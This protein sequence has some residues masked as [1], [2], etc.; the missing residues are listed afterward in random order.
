MKIIN[1]ERRSN[2][3]FILDEID[4][5]KDNPIIE[6]FA[7]ILSEHLAHLVKIFISFDSK[8]PLI[9]SHA[10]C[11]N[12]LIDN[13]IEISIKYLIQQWSVIY[14]NEIISTSNLMRF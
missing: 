12:D 13:F 4:E 6:N 10:N 8:K 2:P 5:L 1:S 7:K 11:N 9:D 14:T 3:K